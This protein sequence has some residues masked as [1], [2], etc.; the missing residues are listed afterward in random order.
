ML[1]A[2]IFDMDGVIVDSEPIHFEVDK[3]VLKKCNLNVND[4]ILNSYVG[5]PNPEMWK[6]LKE[7]YN[8]VPS[9]EELLKL[10]S[11]FK[12]EFLKET[13]IEAI[14]GVKGLLNELKQNNIILAVASSSPRFFIETIL[15]TIK[16]RECFNVILSC[17]EVQRGKPYPDIFL[18]TAEMLKVNPQECIVI[19]DSTNGVKAALS[20]GMRCIGYANLNS[21]LQDLSSAS[22]IVNSICEINYDFMI[23]IM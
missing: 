4:E 14:D 6:D 15:E 22:T 19:E 9:V 1:K 10:Q 11:E 17:E 12:I 18:I 16:I 20:A 21:G 23:S 2:V 13:K 3:K 7:K 5:I 8:L